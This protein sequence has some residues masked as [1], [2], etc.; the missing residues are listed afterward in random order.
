MWKAPMDFK[1]EC[2][3]V[4]EMMMSKQQQQIF[5]PLKIQN[6]KLANP[7]EWVRKQQDLI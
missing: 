5:P 4:K 2:P 7:L 3:F 1:Y 6:Y